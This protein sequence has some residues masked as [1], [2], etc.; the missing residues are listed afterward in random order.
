[1]KEGAKENHDK[2]ETADDALFTLLKMISNK[3][4]SNDSE[5]VVT[6]I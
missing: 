2:N 6:I 4:G 1:M 5:I 3:Q